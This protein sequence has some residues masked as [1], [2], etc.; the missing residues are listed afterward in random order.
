MTVRSGSNTYT[1]VHEADLV[2]FVQDLTRVPSVN[3]PGGE[4][5]VADLILPRL[6][7]LGFDA[8]IVTTPSGR[9]NVIGRYST[10]RPGPTLL[11]NGHMDVLPAGS[12][13]VR[14][15]FGGELD[16]GRIYG[17]GV[18]DMKAG[19][20]AALFAVQAVIRS[21]ANICG[22]ILYTACA[23]EVGGGYEGT[24]YLAKQGLIQ[25]DMAVICEPTGPDVFVAHRGALWADIEVTG[26]SAHGGRP[27]LGVNAISKA[28][29]IIAALETELPPLFAERTHWCLP[30]PTLNIAIVEGGGKYNLVP[31]R[32]II[33]LDR[34]LLPGETVTEA[35]AQIRAVVER[36]RES[37][38]GSFEVEVREK[39][40]VEPAEMP[41]D[42]PI[43][44]ACQD[45]YRTVT[46]WESR[47][48]CTAGF[49]DGHFLINDLGIPTAMFGPY[50]PGP[51]GGD[52]QHTLSGG[53]DE[54]VEVEWLVRCIH[55]YE[56]LILD[57]LDP[58]E[59][60]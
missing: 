50:Q 28:A 33:G 46:G 57:L 44:V 49:E 14:E 37:E 38:G 19:L 54:H 29:K 6:L 17:R 51:Q 32:C 18:L 13:W 59:Q 39:L 25:A 7:E 60:S 53:Y 56:Q 4:G 8:R 27:W 45:A 48:S 30:S 58:V 12:G 23:D 34:R 42:A 41:T 31:D 2:A 26:K 24:G 3:P 55:V 36:L 11:F 40:S 5:P 21:D 1:P 9:A 52:P 43:V 47:I 10:G 15:P 22:D 16:D 35:L 20:A